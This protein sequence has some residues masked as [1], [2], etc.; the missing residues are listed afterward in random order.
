MSDQSDIGVEYNELGLL[1]DADQLTMYSLDYMEEAIPGWVARPASPETIMMEANGQMASEVVAQAA[2]VP[3][4]AM[5]YLGTSIYG[6]PMLD[7][8][9]SRA[10]ATITFDPATPATTIFQGTEV[11]VPHPS[12]TTYLYET[13]R[14]VVAPAGGGTAAL[15]VIASEYGAAQNGCFGISEFQ[16]EFEGVVSIYVDTTTSG[17]D[18]EDPTDYLARFST[19]LSILT[20][21]PVL[22]ID[23]AHR[24]QL[25]PR[26][27]RAVAL[28]L[29]QPAS[30]AGGYGSPR[31][32]SA[33]T[34]VERCCTVVITAAAGA[35]PPDDLMLEVW[36][37]FEAN[38]EVNFLSYVIPPGANGV[39]TAIDVRATVH[40]YPGVADDDART[41][42]IDMIGQWLNP[43]NWGAVPGTAAAQDWSTDNKVRIY[44]AVDWINRAAAIHYVV[45]VEMK[46]STDPVGSWAATDI[47]L[48]GAVPMPTLGAQPVI[49]IG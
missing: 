1:L 44:E 49:T 27:E 9:P 16:E 15:M 39:Y 10:S 36:Q 5:A 24:A 34:N 32:A 22:P 19:Y 35:T 2:T 31:T 26:V 25:N 45:S 23:F 13:D 7:G 48:T 43:A 3:D 30:T 29:Y 21:R 12:G 4:E 18:P 46:K 40:P 42:V 8:A 37:D 14:D 17:A 28:D 38:R 11:A 20:A 41:Q 33:V 6:F 47:T